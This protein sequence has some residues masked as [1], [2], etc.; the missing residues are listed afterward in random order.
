MSMVELL[1]NRR[2]AMILTA[3]PVEYQAVRAHLCEIVEVEHPRGTVYEQGKFICPD[4]DS[5]S[6]GMVEIGAGNPGAAFET[7][8][9]ID[10]FN[11]SVLLFVGVAGGLKDVALCDVVAATKVYGYES[12]KSGNTFL[13]RPDVGESSY[14]M[15]QR[16]RAES[17][18]DRW[19]ERLDCSLYDPVPRVYVAPIAAGEK[20]VTSKRSSTCKFLH[21][22][23]GDAL[24]VE[25]EG[26]GFL[27][28]AQAN[29]PTKALVVRGISDL[30]AGKSK[31][32]SL[33]YQL[34]A[35][36]TASAF[37]FE[38]LSNLERQGNREIGHY[39]LVLSGTID[40][41]DKDRAEAIVAHL[42]ELSKD[43]LLTLIE[44][45]E[46]SVK[47][48]LKG[49]REGFDRLDAL[50]RS[51]GL[52]TIELRWID[53]PSSESTVGYAPI[54]STLPRPSPANDFARA[55]LPLPSADD[56]EKARGYRIGDYVID[57]YIASRG[58]AVVYT[59][60]LPD[61]PQR[62]YALKIFG[63]MQSGPGEL[64]VGL[65]E[66]KKLASLDHPSVVRV[67]ESDVAEIEFRGKTH[68]I[69]YIPMEY[70]NGGNCDENPPFKD[71][72][73]SVVDIHSMIEL[74]DGLKGIH[75]EFIHGD[76]K[77]ANILR[78]QEEFDGEDRTV[79]R[80]TDFGM[81]GF[82]PEF[83]S[84]ERLDHRASPEG[85]IYS[86]GATF[87]Y[88]ITGTLP[89]E[90]PVNWSS[91]Y[92]KIL[93]WQQ[94]HQNQARPNAMKRSIYCPPR[95]ALLIMR[96]MSVDPKDRPNIDECEQELRRI[97]ITHDLQLLQRL[98]LPEKLE[99]EL[100]RNEFPIRYV[101]ADFPGI[102]KPRIHEACDSQL[103]VIRIRM[104][105]LVHS[106]YRVIIE[107]MIRRFSDCFCLYETW[108][109]YDIHILLW[110][111]HDEAEA[112]SLKRRLEETLAGSRVEVR[113]ASRCYDFHCA[114]PGEPEN[115]DPVHALA[116]QEGITLPGLEPSD[117]LCNDFLRDITEQSIHAFTWVG[118]TEP[119]ADRFTRNAILRNVHD[120]L[121][122]LMK[123]DKAS[124][125][126]QPFQRMSVIELLP[127]DQLLAGD[128]G[129][130]LVVNFVARENKFVHEV[131][132][133]IIGALGEFAVRPTTFIESGRVIIESDKILF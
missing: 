118:P 16:A 9:A 85:D 72:H 89:I 73:L 131:P 14:P 60:H 128:D 88:L 53:M 15:I 86:M 94:A 104:G 90:L 103:F 47:L 5:W 82:T 38:I 107:Y 56:Y 32:D 96:M 59:G 101:P 46:G 121:A 65:K 40:Q 126:T 124:S 39:V 6:V 122:E 110:S 130:V 99:V 100:D 37:A 2:H 30:I 42:R 44:I 29:Q 112:V 91:V 129:A 23:Y 12:G 123:D 27:Q 76:I 116:V 83:M 13:P 8:R 80:L 19:L 93:A 67:Y 17:R 102:F 26:R 78:F 4:G 63:L 106:Q 61:F 54:E 57:D 51:L 31:A 108:G 62:K 115:S 34:L 79:L 111:R 98:E 1:P 25:M 92:S 120:E 95:L 10:F 52:G 48:L 119:V 20:V 49:T 18:K 84:P 132:T 36:Q 35:A 97:I 114:N 125:G 127:P 74:L 109:T 117:Y 70:A 105:H 77:P 22:T 24:A 75:R 21:D 11:P 58:Q 133:A 64:P 87:Y 7:E 41:V 3:I 113:T 45:T 55:T 50:F 28:A 43:A 66:A 71:K 81:A 33:G 68:K 69:L